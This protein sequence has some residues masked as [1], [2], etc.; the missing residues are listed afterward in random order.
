MAI[1]NKLLTLPPMAPP[2]VQTP[3]AS[4]PAGNEV[5]TPAASEPKPKDS[6]Q[7]HTHGPRCGCSGPKGSTEELA[8][9][10]D[11]VKLKVDEIRTERAADGPRAAPGEKKVIDVYFHVIARGEGAKNGDVPQEQIEAQIQ[12]LNDAYKDAG[13]EFRLVEVDRTK[14]AQWYTGQPGSR[15]E[16]DMKSTLRKGDSTA[17]NVYTTSPS[18]GLL[19]WATFPSD[20]ESNPVD[21]GVVLLNTSLPG[22]TGAPYNE[23]DTGTHEVGH[24]MG[25]YHTFNQPKGP[26]L[27]LGDMVDDTPAHAEPNFG[28]APE[29]T[30][31][32]PNEP[33]FDP[34]RNFMNYTDDDWMNEFSPGQVDR[35][36]AQWELFRQKEAAPGTEQ[37]AA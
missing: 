1:D 37:R 18:G 4:A 12:V 24:W 16:T 31:T 19:G 8:K 14:N 34:V 21:D 33:G 3:Q 2:A 13:F 25:L 30:D 15:A 27:P 29:T 5:S 11:K 7:A 28:K 6:F 36:Q 9:L 23:G 17:L 10:E 32:L 35:M 20:Y 22:G 26:G